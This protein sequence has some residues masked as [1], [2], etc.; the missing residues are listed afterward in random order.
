MSGAPTLAGVKSCRSPG[1]ISVILFAPEH[2][3]SAILVK[4][5]SIDLFTSKSWSQHAFDAS[6][7]APVFFVSTAFAASFAASVKEGLPS[8]ASDKEA[9][10][11]M[12]SILAPFSL[13]GFLLN[14][15]PS[16]KNSFKSITNF[17]RKPL[18]SCITS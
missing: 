5:S 9:D 6:F 8:A 18:L 4:T 3:Q 10:L 15:I 7:A 12:S 11:V 14:I 13:I 2:I 16:I 17:F 1:F